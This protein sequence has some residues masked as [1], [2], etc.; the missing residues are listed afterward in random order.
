MYTLK[1]IIM[2]PIRAREKLLESRKHVHVVATDCFHIPSKQVQM[3]VYDW[4]LIS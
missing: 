4:L 2:N 1:M 3:I